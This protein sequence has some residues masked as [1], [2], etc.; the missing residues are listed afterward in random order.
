MAWLEAASVHAFER[1]ARDLVAHRAPSALVRR[2]KLAAREEARHARMMRRLARANGATPA[3][4]RAKRWKPRTLEAVATEN[5]IEGCVGETFGA[6][7]AMSDATRAADA[8]LREAMCVIAPDELGHA[9]LAW[10]ISQWASTRL[11]SA[12]NARVR[13]ARDRA[14]EELRRTSLGRMLA[15]H[16][17]RASSHVVMSVTT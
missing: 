13:A 3:R 7:V 10:S 12:T 16:I 4:V 9:A 17:V 11:D 8:H 14:V 15:T 5:A 1:L 6:L 2:A